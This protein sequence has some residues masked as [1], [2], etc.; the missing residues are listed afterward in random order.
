MKQVPDLV[1]PPKCEKNPAFLLWKE[2]RVN[3]T[4]TKGKS[5]VQ[6]NIEKFMVNS[7]GFDIASAFLYKVWGKCFNDFD[8]S[9]FDLLHKYLFILTIFKSCDKILFLELK[10]KF[11]KDETDFSPV[12]MDR[13]KTVI[14]LYPNREIWKQ[15]LVLPTDSQFQFKKVFS[16]AFAGHDSK[17]L[18]VVNRLGRYYK[19]FPNDNRNLAT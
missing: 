11:L 16:R 7:N 4:D 9:N 2:T 17:A 10:Y 13:Y 14:T 3:K 8:K 15:R 18:E 12:L 6:E 5:R 19:T 1:F